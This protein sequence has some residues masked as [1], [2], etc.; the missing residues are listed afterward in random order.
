MFDIWRIGLL[1]K[2]VIE[3]QFNAEAATVAS[4]DWLKSLNKKYGVSEQEE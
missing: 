2:V 1:K 4:G 3:R